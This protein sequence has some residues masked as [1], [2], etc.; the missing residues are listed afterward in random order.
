MHVPASKPYVS[1]IGDPENPDATVIAWHD[2]ASDMNMGTFRT[3]SVAVESDYFCA[4][5][6]TF[7]ANKQPSLT[8]LL[9]IH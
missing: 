2:K 7:Q 4:V 9:M 3:A 1:F 8:L 6:I 5:G